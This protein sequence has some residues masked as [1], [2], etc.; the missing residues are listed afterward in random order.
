MNQYRFKRSFSED[1]TLSEQLFNLLETVFPEI[2]ISHAAEVGRV[3]GAPW[4]AASTPFIRFYDDVAI[5]H[6][7]VLEIPMRIMGQSV[8]VGGIHAVSTR[9]EF[10]RRGYYRCVME[11]VL[12]YCMEIEDTQL[13][14]F[15]LVGTSICTLDA[16]LERIPQHVEEVVIYFSPDRLG[17]EVQAVSHQL[18]G[19]SL[20]MVR[21]SFAAECKQFMLPRSARC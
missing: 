13:K 5:T 14:L 1:P 21:G 10:R 17:V 2:G 12:D 9:P 4:E 19:D 18:G 7:G 15:D 8:R 16:I 6:V 3:L 11:E 20:L